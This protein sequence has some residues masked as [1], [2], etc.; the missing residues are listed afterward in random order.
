MVY[1]I[2]GCIIFMAFPA[3]IFASVEKQWNYLD[4]FYFAFITLTTIGFGDYVAGKKIPFSEA[5]L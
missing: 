3:I 2:V 4:A 5:S 1:L